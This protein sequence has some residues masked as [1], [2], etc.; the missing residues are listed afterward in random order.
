[1][2]RHYYDIV[3]LDQNDLTAEAAKDTGL[4]ADVVKN[5]NIY[6]PDKKAKYDEAKIGTLRLSPNEAFIEQLRQ[7]HEN[8]A[9]MFFGKVP[10]FDNTMSE[11]KRIESIINKSLD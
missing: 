5:K 3:M 2:F 8:M 10:N 7:D 6:F 4:L 9:I 11:V 1:M